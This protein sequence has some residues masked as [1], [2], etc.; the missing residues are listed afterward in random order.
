MQ[1]FDPQS[2]S[3]RAERRKRRYLAGVSGNA[4]RVS[5]LMLHFSNLYYG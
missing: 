1:Y 5:T 4:F 3:I 2:A